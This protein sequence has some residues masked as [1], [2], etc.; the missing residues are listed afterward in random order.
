MAS[1]ARGGYAVNKPTKF[2][3]LLLLLMAFATAFLFSPVSGGQ[4]KERSECEK[5]CRKAHNECRQVP[6][7]NIPECRKSYEGC[8]ESCKET[9]SPEPTVSPS[10]E[11]EPSPVPTVSPT[12]A[13]NPT[14]NPTPAPSP[15]VNPSPAPSPMESPSPLPSPSPEMTPSPSPSV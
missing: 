12:P 2:F 9:P 5:A 14:V 1:Y 13:P 6:G 7:A 15:T 10:P 11:M 8:L 3:A 4:E